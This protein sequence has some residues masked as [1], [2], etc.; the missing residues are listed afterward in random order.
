MIISV[1]IMALIKMYSNNA[2]IFSSIKRDIKTNQYISLLMGNDTYGFEK[3]H[4]VMYDLLK[5][6]DVETD[7]RRDLKSLKVDIL[8][9]E[10]ET[11]DLSEVGDEESE[12]GANSG[13]VLEIGS[14]SLQAKTY[15]ASIMRLRIK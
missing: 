14:S 5:D 1:V 9:K 3:K 2:Y 7:L 11:I 10:V 12:S 15:T 4:I 8:Y 6:F 13:V